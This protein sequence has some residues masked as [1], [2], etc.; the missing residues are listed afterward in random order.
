MISKITP[1]ICIIFLFLTTNIN[2]QNYDYL[3]TATDTGSGITT[4]NS[5]TWTDITSVTIDVTNI[6]SLFLTANINMRPDG[7][8]TNGREA[9]Y[10]IY[11]S[12]ST[13]TNN[14]GII[15]RQIV[16]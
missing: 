2:A 11:Q 8:S 14:S 1:T 13:A 12:D 7:A 3:L 4:N 5:Q 10:N 6:N 9:N 15:K 16:Q